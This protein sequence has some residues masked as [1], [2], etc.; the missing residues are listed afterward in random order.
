MARIISSASAVERV[1]VLPIVIAELPGL[2][3]T[4]LMWVTSCFL[5]QSLAR[6]MEYADWPNL[7]TCSLHICYMNKYERLEIAI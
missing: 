2:D 5:R 3:L 4:G 6:G 1:S 7:G